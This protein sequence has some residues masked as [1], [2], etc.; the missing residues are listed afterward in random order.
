MYKAT[1]E[2]IKARQMHC[3]N[4]LKVVECT[5][6]GGGNVNSCYN[7]SHEYAA[8]NRGKSIMVPGWL[9]YEYDD[10][11]ISD[12]IQHWWNAMIDKSYIDTT[13]EQLEKKA[14]YVVDLDLWDYI[15][16][17]DKN[18]RSHVA[19]SLIMNGKKIDIAQ[20]DGA[21][22][23]IRTPIKHIK[24]DVLFRSVRI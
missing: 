19:S 14:E 16:Q 13:P 17:E 21:G 23:L 15:M 12:I 1:A 22:S 2:F 11:N 20:P 4:K 10:D 24:T 9:V 18:L 7:N 3:K 5:R 8:R 6:V